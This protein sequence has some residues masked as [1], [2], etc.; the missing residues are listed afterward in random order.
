VKLI[1]TGAFAGD[2]DNEILAKMSV[3]DFQSRISQRKPIR[4][5]PA[6]RSFTLLGSMEDVR[7]DYYN[8]KSR[9]PNTLPDDT[10]GYLL[11]NIKPYMLNHIDDLDIISFKLP[12]FINRATDRLLQFA[13]TGIDRSAVRK[14]YQ[15]TLIQSLV[16]TNEVAPHTMFEMGS[17]TGNYIYMRDPRDGSHITVDREQNHLEAAQENVND[18]LAAAAAVG[19]L[20]ATRSYISRCAQIIDWFPKY[21]VGFGNPITAAACNGNVEVLEYLLMQVNRELEKR[22][23]PTNQKDQANRC[24]P[25]TEAITSAIRGVVQTGN[26][27]T[28]V[29]I[30][31]FL[32]KCH[33][34]IPEHMR[35]SSDHLADAMRWGQIELF[36][37][38]MD[39]WD[40]SRHDPSYRNTLVAGLR[41][42]VEHGR[43]NVV[44]HVFDH[45]LVDPNVFDV[46]GER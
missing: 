15:N 22:N 34:G 5:I 21:F 13:D 7:D 37:W 11:I 39:R 40:L 38:L 24:G 3:K 33:I 1:H 8:N 41:L 28:V 19:N 32:L 36:M 9:T 10:K 30:F 23:F 4:A 12:D 42:A 31:A 17:R 35:S 18:M 46:A 27:E 20:A 29:A 14:E 2:I 26:L 25:V 45:G 6:F 43:T 16:L 44:R